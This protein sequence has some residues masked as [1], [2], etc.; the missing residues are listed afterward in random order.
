MWQDLFVL[1]VPFWEKVIRTIAV[2]VLIL[3]IFRLIGKRTISSMSTMDFVM[4]LLLSNV[5]QNAIIGADNSLIGGAIGA[6]VLVVF[7]QLLDNLALS[8]PKVRRFLQGKAT[9]VVKDGW[10][11]RAALRRLGLTK[12]ELEIML[13]LQEGN[14]IDEV[15]SAQMEPDGHLNVQV[16]KK[17]QDATHGEIVALNERLDRIEAL[18]TGQLHPGTH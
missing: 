1:E 14:S 17:Y 16:K 2:Y 12:S 11:D 8:Q 6:I 3:I 15:S 4:L 9:T 5:V 7:N 10:L 13:H 18:I